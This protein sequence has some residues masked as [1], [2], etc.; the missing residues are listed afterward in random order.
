[1]TT[2]LVCAMNEELEVL[3]EELS[4]TEHR[5]S[6][7]YSLWQNDELDLLAAVCRVGK[8]NAAACVSH[9]LSRYAIARII[10]VGVAG[11]I[12]RSLSIGDI[13]ISQDAIQHD[14]SV[15]IFGYEKGTIPGLGIREFPA[16]PHLIASALGHAQA[17]ELPAA[18]GR[19]LS[20]DRFIVGS[21]GRSLREEFQGDC[22]DMETAAWAQVAH[23]YG[24]PWVAIRSISDKAD[25]KATVDFPAFLAL[26]VRRM[27]SLV[28]RMLT[29]S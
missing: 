25:E 11:G 10:G 27:S 2:L 12:R 26:A 17:L 13:V 18:P 23:M 16:H 22:V 20:G 19:I 15:E 21:E 9:V 4:L 29:T 28:A 3:K 24:V 5:D 14:F 1:M 8:V 6:G 7:P